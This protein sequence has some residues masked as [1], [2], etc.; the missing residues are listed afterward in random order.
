ML[1]GGRIGD[2]WTDRPVLARRSK[3]TQG[4]VKP[5]P[6]RKKTEEEMTDSELA[7]KARRDRVAV[8]VE[9]RREQLSLVKANAAAEERR[10]SERRARRHARRGAAAMRIQACAR[11]KRCRRAW[12]SARDRLM[13]EREALRDQRGVLRLQV[14][15]RGLAGRGRAAELRR[16]KTQDEHAL[17]ASRIQASFR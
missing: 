12:L 13:S 8:L 4:F 11:G 3:F 1:P 5:I 2:S 14:A 15:V 10:R 17:M 9:Q 6:P 16:H 7:A